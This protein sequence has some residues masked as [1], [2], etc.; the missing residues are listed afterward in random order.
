MTVETDIYHPV[1]FQTVKQAVKIRIQYFVLL[2]SISLSAPSWA[3]NSV[4]LS[5]EKVK[6]KQFEIDQISLD[7]KGINST[8]PVIQLSL[9]KAKSPGLTKTDIQSF[10][11][12]C[13]ALVLDKHNIACDAADLTLVN[14][15]IQ[16]KKTS[17]SWKY[18]L[19]ESLLDFQVNELL[20]LSGKARLAGKIKQHDLFIEADLENVNLSSDTF[21]QIGLESPFAAATESILSGNLAVRKTSKNLSI[22]FDASLAET[23]FSDETGAFLA[24]SLKARLKGKYQITADES[25]LHGL[26]INLQSGELLTPFF[27]TNLSERPVRLTMDGFS[28]NQNKSWSI[29]KASLKDN[30]I[31][32]RLD[33]ITGEAAKI[34]D[35]EITLSQAELDKIYGFY[36]MPVLT[37]DLAQLTASGTLN[38]R[39]VFNQGKIE[40]YNLNL[41]QGLFVHQPQASK[42]KFDIQGMNLSISGNLQTESSSYISFEKGTLLETIEF[43][44]T[45]FPLLAELDSVRLLEPVNMPVF[46]GGIIIDQFEIAEFG[47][48]PSVK[49]EGLITPISLSRVTEAFDWPVM[50]GKISGIIPAV[51][52]HDG[53]AQFAGTLLVRAFDGNILVKNLE[54]SHL[55][56][57][58]PVMHADLEF[59]EIDLEKL[60][61]TFEF[62]KITGLMNGRFEN[63]QLENWQPTRFDAHFVSSEKS[64]K[65]RISQKAVDNISN[66]GGAGVA[67]ALSRS[68]MRFFEDFGYDKIGF[69]CVLRNNVC[70]M[71]GVEDAQTGFYLVKGGGI[72]RIDVI[73]HNHN[74]DWNI[75]VD[76]LVNITNSGSPTIQ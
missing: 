63:L 42:T 36:F 61:E 48:S 21:S 11:F 32:L 51:K 7:L 25:K 67:G 16:A 69:S 13:D 35:G 23:F 71:S 72:P 49:F 33:R 6:A 9:K 22:D 24:D 70:E 65:K 28:F 66:L 17:S 30:A 76:R 62:G 34:L 2:I 5:V 75:F 59:K 27:Y 8:H 26:N 64:G 19:Q 73:G 46:D 52:Y 41:D 40:S 43:G 50:T 74:I 14:P 45:T 1:F 68:F 55:L 57:A 38:T 58:W 18:N 15:F 47:N 44:Q 20:M 12:R 10:K 37:N 53:N 31:D 39:V 56:S 3:L 54:A 60:T 4:S 29:G